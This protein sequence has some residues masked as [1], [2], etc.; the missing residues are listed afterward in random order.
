MKLVLGGMAE[1]VIMVEMCFQKGRLSEISFPAAGLVYRIGRGILD[2]DDKIS[3]LCRSYPGRAS[4]SAWGRMLFPRFSLSG[5][6]TLASIRVR[7]S[8]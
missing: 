1:V 4:V 2:F 8:L 7:N 6:V 5:T 3:S